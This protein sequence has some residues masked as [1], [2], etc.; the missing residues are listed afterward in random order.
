MQANDVLTV[1]EVAALIRVDP[2]TIRRWII[3]GD[4]PAMRVGRGYR[5]SEA[6]LEE[7]LAAAQVAPTG[8]AS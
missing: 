1:A 8:A 2:A 5:I 3:S 7:Y 4:L 6:A